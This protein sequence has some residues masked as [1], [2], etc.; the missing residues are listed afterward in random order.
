MHQTRQRLEET[1]SALSRSQQCV[2][3]LHSGLQAR[4]ETV[5]KNPPS[6]GSDG[7]ERQVVINFLL[8]MLNSELPLNQRINTIRTMAKALRMKPEELSA[9]LRH[10]ERSFMQFEL[11]NE[12]K[13]PEKKINASIQEKLYDFFQQSE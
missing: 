13:P 9:V 2:D 4:N 12:P 8:N 7:I 3:Q 11:R 10:S 5:E 6:V 1:E